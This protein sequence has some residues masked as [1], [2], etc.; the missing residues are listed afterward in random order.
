MKELKIREIIGTEVKSEDAIIIK[1]LIKENLPDK[2]VLDFENVKQVSG[3]FFPNLLTDLISTKTR[4]YMIS[5]LSVKNLSN[6]K[7]FNRVLFGTSIN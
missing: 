3:G 2:V 6:E 5:V 4:E 7:D 1:R